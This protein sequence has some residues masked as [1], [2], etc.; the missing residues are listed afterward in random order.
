MSIEGHYSELLKLTKPWTVREVTVDD[1]GYAIHIYLEYAGSKHCCPECGKQ[2]TIYDHRPERQWRHL[3][4]MQMTTYLHAR[5]PRVD[6]PEHGVQSVTVPWAEPNSRFTLLFEA[7]AI[8]VMTSTGTTVSGA[9]QL[10]RL[11][12]KQACEIR[13]RA[14]ERGL[15]RR[16]QAEVDYLGIDEKNFGKGHDYVSVLSDIRSRRVLDVVRDRTEEAG[17]ELI[18]K[19]LSEAQRESVKGVCA[20]MW[21][22]Y[23]KVTAALLP[24]ADLV[25]DR[26]HVS[27]HINEGVDQVR[28]TESRTLLAAGDK[29]L[30]GSKYLW[31]YAPDNLSSDA[32]EQLDHL[33]EGDFKVGKAYS[34]GLAFRAFWQSMDVE[35][36]QAFLAAWASRVNQE[37]LK[38]MI[39]VANMLLSHSKGL[40][41][42]VKHR[43]N[44]GTAE[45]FNSKIQ[46]IK[47]AARGFR[48]FA[49]YRDAILFYCGKLD[50]LPDFTHTKV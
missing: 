23:A 10:L 43:I 40:C 8:T 48:N 26:F 29:R 50:M 41:D 31:L 11:G 1:P 15:A 5:I 14:V 4:V 39:K 49:A 3:D 35:T 9:C 27:K 30:K 17:K 42:W 2:C 44:N 37:M 38:P 12:W 32:R 25:H 19:A 33:L 46:Q 45:G 16:S 47:S 21:L 28:R 34:L 20:D 24:S 6:C 22:P 7:H 18:T 13:K 36:A